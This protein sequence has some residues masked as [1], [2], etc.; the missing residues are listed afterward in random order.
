LDNN[1]S[2]QQI[3]GLS[4]DKACE[5]K[6]FLEARENSAKFNDALVK[7]LFDS[8]KDVTPLVQRYGVF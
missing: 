3:E 6:A 2:R 8:N 7:L 1:M 4:P 5:D